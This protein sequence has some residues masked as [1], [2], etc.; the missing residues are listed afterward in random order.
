ME[1]PYPSIISASV[2]N[3]GEIM[4]ETPAEILRN[5][6][7]A[8]RNWT[9]QLQELKSQKYTSS[10]IEPRS[11][12]EPLD[13]YPQDEPY[14]EIMRNMEIAEENWRRLLD[15]AKNRVLPSPL[16]EPAPAL[17]NEEVEPKFVKPIKIKRRAKEEHFEVF[18]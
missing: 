2:S 12:D 7:T 14:E 4:E 13:Y 10:S 17:R 16:L 6:E 15:E 11:K 3:G 5:M 9:R 8:E 18:I 1:A